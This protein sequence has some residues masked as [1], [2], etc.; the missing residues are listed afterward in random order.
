MELTKEQVHS[1]LESYGCEPDEVDKIV[2]EVENG[3]Y[4]SL[5]L[6]MLMG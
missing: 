6:K 2:Q 5:E 4:R 1:I 3:D